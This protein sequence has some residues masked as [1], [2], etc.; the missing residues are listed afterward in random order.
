[1]KYQDDSDALE[2][3]S[4]EHKTVGL[5]MLITTLRIQSA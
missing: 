4:P 5:F 2:V 1:M 3:F